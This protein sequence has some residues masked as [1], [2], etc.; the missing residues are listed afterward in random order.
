MVSDAQGPVNAREFFVKPTIEKCKYA[1]RIFN[2]LP[3]DNRFI[4][5]VPAGST[6]VMTLAGIAIAAQALMQIWT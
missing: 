4:R 1:G 5:L 3:L 6:L 2:R